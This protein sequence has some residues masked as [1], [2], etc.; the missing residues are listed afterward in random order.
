MPTIKLDKSVFERIV[1]KKL[2]PERLKENICYIGTALEKIEGN[3]IHVEVFPN[4][5]DMLSEQGFARAFSSFIGVRKGLV[6]YKVK[7]SNEK[8]I[9]DKSV[10][11]IRPYTACAIV[12]NLNFDDEKIRE[13]IEIQEKLHITYGRKRKRA[14]IGIYPY[15][16]I[17]PPIRFTARKPE[18][19][20][21]R[22]LE[23][24]EE[25]NALQILS[26]H[27]AGR[28]YAHLI[29]GMDKFPIFI[30]SDNNILSMP[31]IINSHTAGKISEKTKEIFIECSGFD[32]KVL[33]ICLNIIVSALADM[34]GDIYSMELVYP[35]KKRVTPDLTPRKMKFDV[36][37]INRIL[38]LELKEKEMIECLKKMGYGYDHGSALIPPYRADV[39]HQI[40]IAEDVAI[41]YGYQNFKEEIPKVATIAHENDLEVFK[42]KI[43]DILVGLGM[44]EVSTYHLLD[45]EMQTKK[46]NMDAEVVEIIDPVSK[47]YN[48]L[49]SWMI[50]CLLNVLKNNKHNEYPQ[51][52]F[53]TGTIFRID[54]KKETG[55]EEAARLGV[56]LCNNKADFTEIKQVLD[57]VFRMIGINYEIIEAEMP[58][59]IPGRVGRVVVKGKKVAYIGEM[60]PVV[61]ENFKLEMPVAA[62][63]LNLSDLF[64]II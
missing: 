43:V 50:P 16:R 40:D 7:K 5:P 9:I 34:G 32:F 24:D 48:S 39:L 33:S 61:L 60:S 14:A 28:E 59:F 4:R 20:R 31:P 46:C 26:R 18:E 64:E 12:K 35:D 38:G 63:E 19:I 2:S 8:V 3:D 55:V 45:K 37:Y 36:D 22:P 49:R 41:A 15:E 44:I 17:K 42:K 21:F 1:G 27:P 58:S 30:D 6:D 57:L 47:D 11:G 29:E 10:S 23:A 54:G 25:M 13:V 62:L 52:I 53:E 51:N 56:L